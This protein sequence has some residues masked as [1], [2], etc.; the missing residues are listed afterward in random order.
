MKNNWPALLLSSVLLAAAFPPSPFPWIIWIAW[1]PLLHVLIHLPEQMQEDK[2]FYW[3]KTPFI[4]I[5]RLLTLRF[6]FQADAWKK[7][8]IR[9][10]SRTQQAFRYLYVVFF[11]WNLLTC[12]WL[13]LTALSVPTDEALMSFIAGIFA[14]AF[15]ALVM[16]IPVLIALK[17]HY[18][19]KSFLSAL[20]FLSIWI[21]FEYLHYH[22]ELS[23]SW[24]TLGNAFTSA[25]TFI[26]FAEFTGVLGVSTWII[27]LNLI[28]LWGFKA[29]KSH[30]PFLLPLSCFVLLGGL[31]LLLNIWI[32]HPDRSVFQSHATL[33]A[34]VIQPNIDP[35]LKFNFDQQEEH[36]Q[37]FYRMTNSPG[38]DTID[39]VVFPETAIPEG[40]WTQQLSS[41]EVMKG[42]WTSISKHP[43]MAIL[44]GLTELRYFEA[45]PI[46]VTAVPMQ[47]G[48]SDYCNSAVI[49]GSSKMR[50]YQKSLLVPMVER[51]PFLDYL[52]FLKDKNI[53][54]GGG[55][56]SFGKA[57]SIF[58]LYTRQDVP[59]GVM[60]C[61][62]STF[63]D[64]VR[65][66][67]LKGAQALSI[68]TNDGWWQQSSG[69]IQ[70]AGLAVLRA[71]ENRREIMRSANTGTSLFVDVYGMRHQDTEWWKEAVIDRKI[72][73]YTE[74]TFYVLHGEYLAIIFLF[75]TAG[76][77]IYAMLTKAHKETV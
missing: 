45:P 8:P 14:P 1:V 39:L 22:W 74:K 24:I 57:D 60:I 3:L 58:N 49:L 62:E 40:V 51:V 66:Y 47:E 35:Y 28:A 10:I 56:G 21:S 65:Q 13:M 18:R 44:T 63:P 26:Q 73:L 36:L 48:Y 27:L 16:S 77:W 68:I 9:Q 52:T 29:I 59:I 37:T 6:L 7:P 42:F 11:I 61:Y 43:R 54:I 12:Y 71:I 2:F 67:T 17:L 32:L 76:I 69:Y 38:A 19:L 25:P 72:N 20:F 33:N 75:L 34:R 70:H 5:W 53:D 41:A 64:Y 23:W 4:Y 46:P 30:R 55:F 15:N 50:T 31:P